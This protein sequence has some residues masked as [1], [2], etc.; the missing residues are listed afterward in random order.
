MQDKS[1]TKSV[2]DGPIQGSALNA[3]VKVNDGGLREPLS[4]PSPYVEES[5]L[6]PLTCPTLQQRPTATHGGR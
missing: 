3:A 6:S 5:R 1:V 4:T 2:V